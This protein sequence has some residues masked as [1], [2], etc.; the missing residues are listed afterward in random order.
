MLGLKPRILC[1]L[2][3]DSIEINPHPSTISITVESR[4]LKS[5]KIALFYIYIF[6]IGFDLVTTREIQMCHDGLFLSVGITR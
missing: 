3:K 5:G 6:N 2:D 4:I 1:I